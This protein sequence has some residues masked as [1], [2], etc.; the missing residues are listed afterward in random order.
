MKTKR[1]EGKIGS[2]AVVL[3]AFAA[4]SSTIGE[5]EGSASTTG[6][7]TAAVGPSS[8]SA[9]TARVPT[10][11]EDEIK[12]KTAALLG[13]FAGGSGVAASDVSAAT[14]AANRIALSATNRVP[15]VRANYDADTDS[16]EAV[17]VELARVRDGVEVSEADARKKFEAALASLV[18]A[19]VVSEGDYVPADARVSRV[20]QGIGSSTGG[21]PVE[22]TKEYRFFVPRKIGGIV[23]NDGGQH[24]I[25]VRIMVHRSGALRGIRVSGAG[26]K[27]SMGNATTRQIA[28]DSLDK[29]VESDFPNS[30]ITPLGLRY[31]LGASGAEPRQVYKVSRRELMDGV[32]VHARAQMVYYS[33]TNASLPPEI[34]PKPNPGDTSNRPRT[35]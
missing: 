22:S 17:D 34:W 5:P 23:V 12:R 25:G 21:A 28:V 14:L 3:L 32:V 26:V 6:T 19:N 30:E 1:L 24:D 18:A 2:T 29:R 31:S 4:C 15:G 27:P 9:V 7:T 16:F 33:A 8:F 11:S 10:R 20:I 35:P 13:V